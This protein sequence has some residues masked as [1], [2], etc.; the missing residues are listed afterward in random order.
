MTRLTQAVDSLRLVTHAGG[1]RRLAI[2][3]GR[4]F[5]PQDG[6]SLDVLLEAAIRDADSRYG[7]PVR[8]GNSPTERLSRAVP[9]IPN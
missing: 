7:G 4:A 1:E 9:M 5:M 8:R 2:T 3:V 6:N